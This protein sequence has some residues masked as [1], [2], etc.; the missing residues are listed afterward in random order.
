MRA[1]GQVA[2]GIVAS[3]VLVALFWLLLQEPPVATRWE[4]W[5]KDG[6][7]VIA[8]ARWEWRF[9]LGMRLVQ[10]T[11]GEDFGALWECRK[12]SYVRQGR[13][14]EAITYTCRRQAAGR[15]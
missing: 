2:K 7:E 1:D 5:I 15:A 11:R 14:W 9:P 8:E 3:L 10:D 12:A 4:L 13:E 6:G